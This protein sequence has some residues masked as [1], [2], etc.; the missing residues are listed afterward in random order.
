MTSGQGDLVL[1]QVDANALAAATALPGAGLAGRRPR[2]LFANAGELLAHAERLA[3][4]A[5]KA[6]GR[7]LWRD[8]EEAAERGQAESAVG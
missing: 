1:A 4:I 7:V 8:E 2:V 3:R 5:K 6:G